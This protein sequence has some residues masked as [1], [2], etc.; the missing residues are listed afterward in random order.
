MVSKPPD[1]AT[2][3]GA[4]APPATDSPASRFSAPPRIDLRELSLVRL[5][6]CLL[7]AIALVSGI[8]GLFL[9]IVP[10]APF[11]ILA[12]FA[13]GKGSPALQNWLEQDKTFGP[14]I[15]NWRNNGAIA[16]RYKLISVV[17]MAASV[18]IAALLAL[19]ATV[20]AIQAACLGLAAIYIVTRPN[21]DD[22]P[23]QAG[24]QPPQA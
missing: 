15:R 22:D 20:I 17:T 6:W 14:I 19:P 18:A 12:A 23:Q 16:P 10:T 5:L 9:P 7:G 21:G 13:F 8:I 4:E 1:R 3:P 24:N 11:V 2:L